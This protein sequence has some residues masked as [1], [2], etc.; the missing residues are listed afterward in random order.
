MPVPEVVRFRPRDGWSGVSPSTNLSVRFTTAMDHTTTERA[1][2]A[3]LPDG[4]AIVGSVRWAEGDTV[5]VL[6]PTT[7][8]PRGVGVVLAVAAGALS[9]EGVPLAAATSVT[10]TV[11]A[12]PASAPKRATVPA[13]SSGWRWPLLGPITQYFGQSLTVYG[14]HQGIDID[15]NTGDP[16]R[17]AHAGRVVVAGHY[18]DCGGLEVHIDHGDGVASWYRHLSRID[19]AVGS[20]VEAGTVIGLV[21]TTGCALGSHL[22]FAVRIGSTFVDPLSYLP[23]R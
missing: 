21:G 8:L 11:A 7:A 18:D 17:A 16:V 5:L 10:F 3:A 19:V 15:G 4:K 14:F 6:D 12:P 13:T 23:P 22:H 9:A 2:S 1:F 20:N